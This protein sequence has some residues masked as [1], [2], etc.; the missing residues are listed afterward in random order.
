MPTP[1][2]II[3][4]CLFYSL[5]LPQLNFFTKLA[6]K[7]IMT[8]CS[9]NFRMPYIWWVQ[10]LNPQMLYISER[11]EYVFRW[12]VRIGST[13]I[14]VWLQ[15]GWTQIGIANVLLA[16]RPKK[17]TMQRNSTIT[18]RSGSEKTHD[19]THNLEKC[20]FK[21]NHRNQNPII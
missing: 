20:S 9:K 3:L 1:K 14:C 7:P 2:P 13:H 12:W 4:A 15:F 8:F 21:I 11:R 16:V 18:D 19:I 10:I 5:C 17:I 6:P